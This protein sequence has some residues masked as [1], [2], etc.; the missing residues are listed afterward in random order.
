MGRGV[1]GSSP[2]ICSMEE[3]FLAVA[4]SGFLEGRS[5]STLETLCRRVSP[6]EADFDLAWS[7]ECRRLWGASTK[8][9]TFRWWKEAL[10]WLEDWAR[11]LRK[12]DDFSGAWLDKLLASAESRGLVAVRADALHAL[13]TRGRYEFQR[14]VAAYATQDLIKYHA[15]QQRLNDVKGL[16][17]RY[18]DVLASSRD[19]EEALRRVLNF[20]PFLPARSAHGADRVIDELSKVYADVV[21]TTT[22]TGTIE[23][24]SETTSGGGAVVVVEKQKK[25]KKKQPPPPQSSCSAVTTT[26][27]TEETTDDKKKQAARS[28]SSVFDSVFHAEQQNDDAANA[29]YILWYSIA[30]LNTDLHNPKVSSKITEDGF[31]R[32]LSGTI[33]GGL[34][35]NVDDIARTLY[36][37]VKAR[38]LLTGDHQNRTTLRLT[39]RREEAHCF[40]R[41][42]AEASFPSR[43]HRRGRR[44]HPTAAA[45]GAG[46]GPFPAAALHRLDRRVLDRVLD[47]LAIPLACLQDLSST[48]VLDYPLVL[49]YVSWA[50]ILATVLYFLQS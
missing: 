12:M 26:T 1:V 29:T 16:C 21:T 48:V 35:R 10:R 46:G 15:T 28:E 17:R 11:A 45:A 23:K 18:A 24:D 27:T 30:L 8:K 34:S 6:D 19:V 22:T 25:K 33:L 36:R 3:A 41:A 32:S 38:P 39:V 20:F 40:P 44:H 14:S 13:T 37:S 42:P 2:L 31:A 9:G 47:V 7:V 49:E 50:T 5:L 4:R 43:R